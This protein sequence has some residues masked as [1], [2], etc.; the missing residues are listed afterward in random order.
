[1]NS[2]FGLQNELKD[3][4]LVAL[5]SVVMDASP[6]LQS[7]L[8]DSL[9]CMASDVVLDL[10]DEFKESLPAIMKQVTARAQDVSRP[11]VVMEA[12]SGLQSELRDSL[13]GSSSQVDSRVGSVALSVL[14]SVECDTAVF[15]SHCACTDRQPTKIFGVGCSRLRTHVFNEESLALSTLDV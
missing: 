13:T 14:Q 2:P 8:K 6:A 5:S 4:L 11:E 1:M 3:P 10:P 12:S 15:D 7:E 9:T